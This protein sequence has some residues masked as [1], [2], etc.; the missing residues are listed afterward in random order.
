MRVEGGAGERRAA[1]FETV[2]EH[3]QS[4]RRHATILPFVLTSVDV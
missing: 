3:W 2:G 4:P 1:D